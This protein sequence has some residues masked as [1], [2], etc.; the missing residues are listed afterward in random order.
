MDYSEAYK[1][2]LENLKNN[3]CEILI[4]DSFKRVYG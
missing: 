1:L 3:E 4:T 2:A